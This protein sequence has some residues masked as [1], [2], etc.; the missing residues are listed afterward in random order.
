VEK[1]NQ[2]QINLK[3]EKNPC[4]IC[5]N[6]DVVFYTKSR[7]PQIKSDTKFYYA[8]KCTKCDIVFQS[9][10]PS[11][12]DF[13]KIYP[14]NYYA[15]SNDNVSIPLLLKFLDF[16]LQEKWTSKLLSPLKRS[17][18]PHYDIIKNAN[19]V[20]DIGC[21]K[22][23][24]LDILKKHGKDTHALEPDEGATKILKEKGHNVCQGDISKSNYDDNYFDLITAF[25]VFEHIDNPNYFLKEVYRILKPGGFLIIEMPNINSHLA[26]FKDKWVNLDLPRHLILYTPTSIKQ[27]LDSHSFKSETTTRVSPSDIKYTYLRR[28]N[29]KSPAKNRLYSYLLLPT[30]FFQYIFKAKKGSL[31]ISIAKKPLV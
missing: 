30:I 28:K 3:D 12:E 8:Y 31:L 24:F 5:S 22:G 9:P 27:L 17:V 7:D 29:I 25:Q 13:D 23:L 1:K 4:P 18:Y 16:L 10:F 20:L 11:K 6:Q 14:K 21:G 2:D 19:R 15:H 26:S